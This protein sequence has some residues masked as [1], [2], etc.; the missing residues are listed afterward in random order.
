[1]AQ[2]LLDFL[3]KNQISNLYTIH[4]QNLQVHDIYSLTHPIL[5]PETEITSFFNKSS[6]AGLSLDEQLAH[7]LSNPK[8]K[9]GFSESFDIS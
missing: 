6:Y 7:K 9:T 8:K 4:K 5:P 1:M 3:L 2:K